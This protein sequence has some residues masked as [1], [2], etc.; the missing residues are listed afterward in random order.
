DVAVAFTWEEWQLLA[1]AQKALYWDVTLENY[2]NLVSVG[3]DGCPGSLGQSMV[4]S[5]EPESSA[6]SHEQAIKLANL[7]Y[8]P[9]WN[10]KNHHGP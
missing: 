4:T 9:S 10:E 2:G 5:D 8:S 7:M 3:E 1:P 6:I